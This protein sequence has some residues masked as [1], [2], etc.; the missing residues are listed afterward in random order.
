[1]RNT[2]IYPMQIPKIVNDRNST[3]VAFIYGGMSAEREVSIMSSAGLIN[4][5]LESGYMV[6]PI[7]MGYDFAKVILPLKP[8]LVYNG[9]Y[10]TYGEDGCVPG[11]LEIMGLKYTHSGVLASAVAMNKIFSGL[12]FK[13]HGIKC[14]NRKV[15]ERN[16]NISSDPMP[17]PYV[18]KPINQG[19]S[20]GVIVVFEEDDFEFGD[21][22]WA[23]GDTILVEDYIQGQEINVAVLCDKAIGALEIKPLKRRFYDYESKYQD[24]MTQ[25]IMPANLSATAYQ[26]VLDISI[27]AHTLIGCK[28]VSR[29]EFIYNAK[30]GENG[31]FY[32]LEIN[33]H[34]GMTPLSLVPEVCAYYGITFAQLVDKI[35]QDALK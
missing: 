1:M 3:H 4:G 21:Y 12:F 7:D 9:L 19:S 16:Q 31:E 32:I 5:L 24:N 33:T 18:V 10:G 28:S 17:R 25:H 6:T 27:K 8:D 35:A 14:A 20:I 29:V 26:R 30:E 15:I 13:D 23:Y 2:I 34:P 11:A 22:D